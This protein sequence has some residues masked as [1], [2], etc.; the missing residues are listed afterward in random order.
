MIYRMAT[1]IALLTIA[2]CADEPDK[3][4]ASP[5][6]PAAA[7]KSEALASAP[8]AMSGATVCLSYGRDRALV[9]A[10]LK[11]GPSPEKLEKLQARLKALDDLILDAC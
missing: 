8:A 2:G 11:G 10:E 1:A 3:K 5:T 9:R 6:A 4:S 7:V